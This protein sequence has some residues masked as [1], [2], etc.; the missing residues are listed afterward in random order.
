MPPPS[1][2][3]RDTLARTARKLARARAEL[4][5]I[6]VANRQDGMF[7]EHS[8]RIETAREALVKQLGEQV[9]DLR[10]RVR[11]APANARVPRARRST[12]HQA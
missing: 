2:T 3:L 5:A 11:A 7:N 9:A 1:N 10:N 12:R 4:A 6:Q 8:V